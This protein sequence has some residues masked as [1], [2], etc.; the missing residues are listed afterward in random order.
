MYN[1]GQ[2]DNLLSAGRVEY[3]KYENS[4][5]TKKEYPC[6]YISPDTKKRPESIPLGIYVN[7]YDE[8]GYIERYVEDTQQ[9][10]AGEVSDKFLLIVMIILLVILAVCTYISFQ[11]R[12]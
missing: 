12:I 4:C 6:N 11:E 10:R 2:A 1:V 3:P 9:K 7:P 8:N 5:V